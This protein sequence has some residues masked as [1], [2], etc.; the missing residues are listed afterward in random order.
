VTGAG[1]D[2][3]ALAT[4]AGCTGTDRTPAD[5]SDVAPGAELSD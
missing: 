2:R 4:S 1:S 3:A 5:P